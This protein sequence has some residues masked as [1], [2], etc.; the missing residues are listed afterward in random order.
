M[1]GH[2]LLHVCLAVRAFFLPLHGI[3]QTPPAEIVLAGMRRGW[4]ADDL[5]TA[6]THH[7]LGKCF[8]LSRRV[9]GLAPEQLE[10]MDARGDFVTIVPFRNFQCGALAACDRRVRVV[11]M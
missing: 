5:E 11:M 6:A 2:D 9:S 10:R 7:L 8:H 1:V 4:I 3:L